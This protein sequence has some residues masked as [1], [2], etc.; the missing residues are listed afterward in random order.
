VLPGSYE[1]FVDHIAPTLQE[2]GLMQSEYREGTLREKLFGHAQLPDSHPARQWHGAFSGGAG[3]TE[4][5]D[6]VEVP[7]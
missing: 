4:A 7:A 3:A 5:R 6:A 1:E 2:R